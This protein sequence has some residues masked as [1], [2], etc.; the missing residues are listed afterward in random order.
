M[1]TTQRDTTFGD[2]IARLYE[3]YLVPLIFQPYAEATAQ[4]LAATQPARVLEIACGTGVLTR[5]LASRLPASCSITASDL[6]PAMLEQA[7][8]VGTSRP[9]SWRQADALAL[10]F[11][12]ESFD[13]VVCEFG[14]MFFPDKSKA[15]AEARRV[16]APGG[17]YLFSVWA[18]IEDNEI[19]DV[20]TNALASLFPDDPPSFMRRTPHGYH[21]RTTIERDLARGGFDG[22][23]EFETITARSRAQSAREAAIGIC[24]GTPLRNEIEARDPTR[25][26]EATE[27]ATRALVARFGH[28]AIDAAMTAHLVLVRRP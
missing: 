24:E 8:R 16:L 14:A 22:P 19:T 7:K 20:A 26:E 4:Q 6:N 13:A 5:E 23:V 15:F 9:V 28:G 21:D 2:E 18:A 1:S 3:R 25:L 12:D 10:P 27:V 11:P 17:V